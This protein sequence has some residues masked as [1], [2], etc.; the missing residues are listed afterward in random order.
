M[1]LEEAHGFGGHAG[2]FFVGAAGVGGGGVGGLGGF[3]EVVGEEV[4]FDLFAGD[5]GEHDAVNFDARGEGL[6]GLLD[7]LGVVVAV[8]D[9]VDVFVGETVFLEDGADAVGPAALGFEI[10]FDVHGKRGG[11]G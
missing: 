5:V 1:E 6:A 7:H 2:V 9:D 11:G 3:D 10:G 4:V 8:V